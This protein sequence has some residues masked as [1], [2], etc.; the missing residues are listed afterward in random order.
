MRSRHL[1]K[2]NRRRDGAPVASSG[3][4]T[5]RRLVCSEEMDRSGLRTSLLFPGGL[6]ADG[7][8]LPSAVREGSADVRHGMRCGVTRRGAISPL[9]AVFQAEEGAV[10]PCFVTAVS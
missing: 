4:S 6:G 1:V 5:F 3:S 8:G 2:G 7:R 9:G 10:H